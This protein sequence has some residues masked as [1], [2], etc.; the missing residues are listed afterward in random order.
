VAVLL[1]GWRLWPAR[2][3]IPWAI[4]GETRPFVNETGVHGASFGKLR[5]VLR[6]EFDVARHR[7]QLAG[8]CLHRDL[9]APG[10]NANGRVVECLGAN[11]AKASSTSDCDTWAQVRPRFASDG[12]WLHSSRA[13]GGYSTTFDHKGAEEP[14]APSLPPARPA[15]GSRVFSKRILDVLHARC[16]QTLFSWANPKALFRNTL[17]GNCAVGPNV[18]L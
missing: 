10:P 2:S 18:D 9:V 13:A 15:P 4:S 5:D 17:R 3:R 16:L 7:R 6:A 12:L 1:H 11:A 14:F 8:E